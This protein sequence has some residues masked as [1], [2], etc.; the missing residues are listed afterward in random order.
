MMGPELEIC[1]GDVLAGGVLAANGCMYFAPY[2]ARQVLCVSPEA[3]TAEMMGPE[4]EGDDKFLAG[5][6]LAANGCVYFAPCDARQ[7]L[8]VNPEAG[9]VEMMGPELVGGCS[10]FDKFMADGVL[11]AN[12]C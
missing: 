7:V 12:G 1:P 8:C 3:G 9:T 5:G 10:K 11:A 2:N 4:L 6:V